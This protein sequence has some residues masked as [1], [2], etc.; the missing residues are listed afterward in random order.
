MSVDMA[1]K[2]NQTN[3]VKPRYHAIMYTASGLQAIS[4][5]PEEEYVT[6]QRIL[7]TCV[8]AGI[9]YLKP[10]PLKCGFDPRHISNMG[11]RGLYDIYDLTSSSVIVTG[12]S[13]YPIGSHELHIL[14]SPHVQ[15]WF[16]NNID[17]PHP[18]LVSVPLGLPNELDFP[19]YGNT[20]TLFKVVQEPK[21][22]KNLAYMNFKIET[23]PRERQYVFEKFSKE[24]WVTVAGN[25]F[26]NEGHE[27]YL[28]EIKSH[29]F[30]IC[31]RGN[32]VDSHR[33]WE[34]L[35][36][37]TIPICVKDVA[38]EQFSNLPILFVNTW[39]EV[40]P[41]LLVNVYDK[42][43]SITWDTRQLYMSYWKDTIS[44]N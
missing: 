38:L 33:L 14:E 6:C 16:A 32:G 40:T 35:Y 31:P 28:R 26:S 5:I 25:D 20:R 10:D 19:T 41:D 2:K 15:K 39:D 11:W 9:P 7:E 21:V 30:C 18:K 24:D 3:N 17:I 12:Y 36:L 42:F 43:E 8:P 27:K 1:C 23:C 29:K 44:F 4:K 34:C 22:V 13:D 37:G